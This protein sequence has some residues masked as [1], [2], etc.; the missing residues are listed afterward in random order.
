MAMGVFP[1]D[2]LNFGNA[3]GYEMACS[4]FASDVT[5]ILQPSGLNAFAS[6]VAGAM[7]ATNAFQADLLGYYIFQNVVTATALTGGLITDSVGGTATPTG[8]P[9]A[10]GTTATATS[11]GA[12]SR[13]T[14]TG[15]ASNGNAASTLGTGTHSSDSGR[16]QVRSLAGI[17][18]VA[19]LVALL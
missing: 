17:L 10:T 4:I 1:I 9:T 3:A 15:S 12:T 19:A 14:A 7:T 2:G 8:I 11:N 6:V 16:L 13:A 18:A 5:S